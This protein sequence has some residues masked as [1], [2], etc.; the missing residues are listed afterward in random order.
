M[1]I[2]HFGLAQYPFTL[3]PNTRYFLKLPSHQKAFNELVAALND[4]GA[5]AKITGEVGTG[6]TMLCRKLLNALDTHKDKYATAY[7]P[8]PI[9][10][11]EGIMHAI[12]EE[13]T[14]HYKADMSYYELLK[15]ITAK[16]VQLG[17]DGKQLVLF[18]DEAQAMPQESLEAV[19][20]LTN[21]DTLPGRPMQ[22]VL[23]AQPELDQ[24]L[25]QPQL[26]KI[27]DQ[28]SYAYSLPALSRDGVEAY[29]QHRLRKAGYSGP[30]L[31]SSTALDLLFFS[32]QGIPRLINILAHKSMMVAFGRGDRLIDAPHL[33]SAVDDTDSINL[34][35]TRSRRWF[36]R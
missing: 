20:L 17:Q 4:E 31:F 11:E 28:I 34:L 27:N 16:L 23:F 13:L 25:Q 5:F 30:H 22:V 9:L 7:I 1:Y 33:Q 8:H 14:I 19:Y 18:I 15:L 3:T 35:Q 2:Q 36:A 21:L 29:V 32:S 12:A 10:S 6:R 26:G 24:I